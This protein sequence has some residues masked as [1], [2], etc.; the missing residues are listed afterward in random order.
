M[1]FAQKKTFPWQKGHLF[2]AYWH[3]WAKI[4]FKAFRSCRVQNS[5]F[6]TS[7]SM[8]CRGHW[9]NSSPSKKFLVKSKM[10]DRYLKVAEI[11][12][13][14]RKHHL[15]VAPI[16]YISRKQIHCTVNLS[17]GLICNK[18]KHCWALSTNF[19]FCSANSFWPLARR[20]SPR[21]SF[22]VS[23]PC[24]IYPNLVYFVMFWH[25]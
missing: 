15:K 13:V 24:V 3:N 9:R 5:K 7:K 8:S 17:F 6:A 10:L 14:S 16:N 23:I 1:Q 2:L 11:N 25:I 19:S 20:N 21:N 4:I 22:V 12:Y 18:V